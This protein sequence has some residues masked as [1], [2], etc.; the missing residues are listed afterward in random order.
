VEAVLLAVVFLVVIVICDCQLIHGMEGSGFTLLADR[1]RIL[2]AIQE[3]LVVMITEDIIILVQLYC[4]PYKF[5]IIDGN[6]I[7]GLYSELVN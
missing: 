1:N 6:F 4:I 3:F 5:H 2:K 7:F